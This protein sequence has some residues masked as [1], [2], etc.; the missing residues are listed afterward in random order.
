MPTIEASVR[1]AAS[2]ADIEAVLLDAELAPKWT[3]G[4][5]RLE[6]ISGRPGGAGSVG[7][8]HYREGGRSYV[9]TDV[10]EEVE[11]GRRYLSRI[12]GGGIALRV[13][14]LLEPVADG[15]TQISLRWSGRGT[16]PVT[17]VALPFMRAR[18]RERA[19]ADLEALKALVEARA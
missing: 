14:T 6:L 9:L 12:S 7:H 8:A 11:P 18:V 16:N 1:I 10:L 15:E 4:L 13:E 5:E 17:F 19:L 2:P 3:S